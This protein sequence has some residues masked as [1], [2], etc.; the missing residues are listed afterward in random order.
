MDD[1]GSRILMVTDET[2]M[3]DAGDKAMCCDLGHW[4]NST[5]TNKEDEPPPQSLLV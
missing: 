1:A 5:R 2:K 4:I 3:D